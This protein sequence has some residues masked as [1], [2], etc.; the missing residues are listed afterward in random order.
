[1]RKHRLGSGGP[2]ISVLGIGTWAIGGPWSFGLGRVDDDASVRALGSAIEGG[3]NWVDTAPT[4]GLGHAEEV[5]GRYLSRR[6]GSE[7]VL[8][9]TKCGTNLSNLRNDL[10]P[11]SIREECEASLRRLGVECIDLYQIHWPDKLTGTPVE[12]SW[13]AMGDLVERGLVRW[14]GVSNFDVELLERC[15][16]IRHV[17]SLQPP[18]NVFDRAAQEDVIPWCHDHGTGVIC[19]SPLATG[20]LSGSFGVSR[21]DDLEPNDWRRGDPRFATERIT[22]AAAWRERIEPLAKRKN[23]SVVEVAIAWVLSVP[24]VTGAIVGARR[25]E[26]VADW[27]PAAE[28]LL[29]QGDLEEIESVTKELAL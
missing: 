10:R 25:P 16:A 4:Y 24:G 7:D 9:F 15:E 19:Y 27:L 21:R 14:V 23:A 17:D 28:V 8:V 11:P 3:S 20:V 2:E 29:D 5:V 12:E 1:V 18:L 26:Q 13:G 6:A 22:A